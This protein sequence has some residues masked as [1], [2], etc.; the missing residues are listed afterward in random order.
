[1]SRMEKSIRSIEIEQGLKPARRPALSTVVDILREILPEGLIVYTEDRYG[2]RTEY[3]CDGDRKLE[4]PLAVLINGDS[5]SASEIFA[6]A[7]KD[8]GIGT[9]VGTT[10]FGKGI[11]QR[12]VELSDGTAVKRWSLPP[13]IS[14][15]TRAA[16]P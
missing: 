12:I 3:S 15:R 6:G 7:V 8:Y 14:G 10:T 11:V 5:A 4:I 1:M 16:A 2:N 9:L 13:L